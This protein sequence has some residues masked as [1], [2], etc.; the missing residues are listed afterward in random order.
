MVQCVQ[1]E[2]KN[3]FCTHLLRQVDKWDIHQLYRT[4]R[5]FLNTEN[6][7]EYGQRLEK[8]FTAQIKTGEDIFT[9]M[10]RLDKYTE[11]IGHLQH[12][13]EE[14][15]E[16]LQMP[17]F[18]RVWKVL[19]AV[20]KF[21]EYRIFTDKIQQQTPQEWIVLEPDTIRQELHKIHSNRTSLK[22]EKG[23]VALRGVARKT[24]PPPPH[25]GGG[26]GAG[27]A[28]TTTTTHTPRAGTPQKYPVSDKLKHFNCPEC[29]WGTSGLTKG[30]TV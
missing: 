17:K 6:Y 26:G 22:E 19:S 8:Y 23:E 2:E 15:G 1:G 24:P 20:E 30:E 18:Y 25:D 5:D 10:S 29:V 13:A 21:P 14:A 27:R 12:L 16:T 3:L 4:I 9:Y 11:E 7:K 28:T